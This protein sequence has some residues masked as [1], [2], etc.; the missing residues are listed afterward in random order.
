[1]IRLWSC[2]NARAGVCLAVLA[3]AVVVHRADALTIR[4][5]VADSVYIDLAAQ[6]EYESNGR[7]VSSVGGCTAT[8]IHP[9]WVLTAAHCVS[10][11]GSGTVTFQLGASSSQIDLAVSADSWTR[12]PSYTGNDADLGQGNDFALVHLSSPILDI[13]PAQLYRGSSE[14][15]QTAT[16]VGYGRSGTGL[17]GDTISA[18]TKRAGTNVVDS[19][20]T[21]VITG[22]TSN[23]IMIDFD[24]PSNNPNSDNPLG[25]PTPTATEVGVID[26][27]S[28]GGWFA[29]IGGVQYLIGVTSFKATNDGN[30]NADYGDMGG[31]GRVGQHLAFIDANHD[32]TVFSNGSSFNWNT[33]SSWAGGPEPGS[34]NAAVINGGTV[35]VTNHGEVVKYLYVQDN[36]TLNITG[37][38]LA[39]NAIVQKT[40]GSIS[41]T[42]G[43]LSTTQIIGSLVNTGGVFAPGASPAASTISGTYSQNGS[44]TLQIELTGPTAGTQYDRLTVT[45]SVSLDGALDLV[46]TF[47]P[48]LAASF[49][50]L[51]SNTSLSGQF[52]TVAGSILSDDLGLAVTYLADRVRVV[53]ATPGDLN[54]DGTVNEFDLA[55]MAGNWLG[56]GQT[57]LGGDVNGD[58]VVDADDLGYLA[59]NWH[60]GA[61][62]ASSIEAIAV[63]L[64]G[65][66][67]PEPGTL[68]VLVIGL[69][70]T[71]RRCR[72]QAQG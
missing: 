69:T 20:A 72:H 18:G 5:D 11:N 35:S 19:Y 10:G 59:L 8:L 44:S 68:A 15:G 29:T 52:D 38:S 71:L 36:G 21:G 48:T 31:A 45:G 39:A 65:N 9:E 24:S 26:G 47:T 54:L 67:I 3:T 14:L 2:R 55:V 28:G 32:A 12:H 16:I 1:M 6:P 64:D 27:D 4:H 50:V 62:S 70:L 56:T 30:N 53:A 63:S 13:T 22:G 37:G 41:F 61:L 49:D 60:S 25:L 43:T 42:G 7:L 34:A 58:G 40:G 57:W 33:D 51:I 66:A 46:T 23:V 17:T